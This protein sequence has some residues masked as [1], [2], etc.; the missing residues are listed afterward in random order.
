MRRMSMSAEKYLALLRQGQTRWEVL[1]MSDT[2]RHRRL[3]VSDTVLDLR[4]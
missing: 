3:E 4:G 2:D 1:K